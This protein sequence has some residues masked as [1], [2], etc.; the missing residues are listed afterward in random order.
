M[1]PPAGSIKA[2]V[3]NAVACG[4]RERGPAAVGLVIMG[5]ARLTIGLLTLFVL[6]GTSTILGYGMTPLPFAGMT[7][8]S[9]LTTWLVTRE[10]RWLEQAEEDTQTEG[11]GD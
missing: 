11:P 10:T 3:G 4:I 6:V 8:I 5:L 7:G 2:E 1:N 9:A